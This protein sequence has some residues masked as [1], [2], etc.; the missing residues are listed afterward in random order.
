MEPNNLNNMQNNGEPVGPQPVQP[1]QPTPEQPMQPAQPMMNPL[2]SDA[3]PMELG[4]KPKPK[5]NFVMIGIIA[6]VAVLL[7][8]VAII[9]ALNLGS[10]KSAPATPIP[11]PD[12]EAKSIVPTPE[13]AESVC[14]KYNGDLV[15]SEG[16]E[17]VD[18]YMEVESR[19]ICQR[20]I[21]AQQEGDTQFVVSYTADDFVYQVDFIKED[22]INE[23]WTRL[24][25]TNKTSGNKILEDSD[26][27][28]RVHSSMS[29]AGAVI[30]ETDM[31]MYKEAT[32]AISTYDQDGSLAKE[33]LKELGFLNDEDNEDEGSDEGE[34][35]GKS[36]SSARAD[37]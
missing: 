24:K 9:L 5:I 26:D 33:I 18:D 11:D 4:G 34:D 31:V 8:I 23:R 1:V 36:N 27:V 22:K 29:G 32:V 3:Q 17:V 30:V 10:K 25:A 21:N 6:G 20:Y 2:Q 7:A 35:K 15:V 13:L 14:K 28:M 12:T 19:Y 37:I 16:E